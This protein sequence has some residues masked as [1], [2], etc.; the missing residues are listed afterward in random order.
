VQVAPSAPRSALWPVFVAY[1]VAFFLVLIASALYLLVPAV[2]RAGWDPARIADEAA[3]FAFSAPG[4]LGA[5]LVSAVVLALVTLVTARLMGGGVASRLSAGPTR[6]RP[7]GVAAAVVGLAGLSLAC[8]SA[9]QLAGLGKAG[10]TESIAQALRSSNPLRIALAVLCIGIA[11]A[12]AEEGFFRGLMQ[13]RLRARWR[14]WPAIVV[15]ALAFGAFHVDPVQGTEAFIAG[16]FFG[17]VVDRF[18]G[19]RPS[20]AAHAFNNA[21]FVVFASLA[22]SDEPGTRLVTVG[23]LV[24]GLVVCAGAAA[25]IRSRHAV[26]GDVT[27][28]ISAS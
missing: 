28:S 7:A 26:R 24:G 3:S 4:L 9:A 27:A 25:L 18:G 16:I 17:W 8:G 13:T 20:I 5:A 14:R 2:G 19:I 6:A 1:V 12:F 11:P 21:M 10:V 15:T 22:A 23:I